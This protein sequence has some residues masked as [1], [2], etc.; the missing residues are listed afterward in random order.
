VL[1][2]KKHIKVKSERKKK[3]HIVPSEEKEE[4]EAYVKKKEIQNKVLIK[5]IEEINHKTEKDEKE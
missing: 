5:I 2:L 1:Q 4:L 3:T